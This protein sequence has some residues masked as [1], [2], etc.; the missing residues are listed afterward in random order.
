MFKIKNRS[1]VISP[2]L[3][4]KTLN[5]YNG[6]KYLPV[7]IKREMIGHKTGEFA[8]TKTLGYKPKKKEKPKLKEKKIRWAI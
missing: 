2:L 5:I 7:V 3:L 1:T 6:A 8:I 4:S